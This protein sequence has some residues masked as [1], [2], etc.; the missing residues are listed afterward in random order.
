[1]QINEKASSTEIYSAI[2]DLTKQGYTLYEIR[3][4]LKNCSIGEKLNSITNYN[5]FLS[6]L[7]PAERQNLKTALEYEEFMYPWLDDN[8]RSITSYL[9]KTNDNYNLSVPYKAYNNYRPSSYTNYSYYKPSYNN[10]YSNDLYNRG[11]NTYNPYDV[12]WDM[13]NDQAYQR[14]Q[15]DYKNK[16]KHWEDN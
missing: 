3:S 7:T 9:N 12:Y 4:A 16:Q 11:N 8:V 14:Q 13:V 2:N 5:Q 15:A 1:M 10:P 6:S